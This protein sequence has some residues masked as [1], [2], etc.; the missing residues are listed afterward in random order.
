MQENTLRDSRP[1]IKVY[2]YISEFSAKASADGCP[3]NCCGLYFYGI[4]EKVILEFNRDI[5]ADIQQYTSCS[6]ICD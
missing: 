6:A 2:H 1:T 4:M 5:H 3:S